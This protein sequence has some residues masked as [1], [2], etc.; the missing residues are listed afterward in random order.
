MVEPLLCGCGESYLNLGCFYDSKALGANAGAL[1]ALQKKNQSCYPAVYAH[2]RAAAA[3]EHSAREAME[4]TDAEGLYRLLRR[5][6]G[7]IAPSHS[8]RAQSREI[9]L[10]AYT[11]A[12][13][14]RY[15]V[16]CA[17][18]MALEDPCGLSAPLFARLRNHCLHAGYDCVT[19]LSPLS[20]DRLT[21]L[22]IPE[23]DTAFLADP[24]PDERCGVR[25]NLR[26][27]FRPGDHCASLLAEAKAHTEEAVR[28]LAQAK[29]AHDELEALYRPHVAFEGLD[30]LTQEYRKN[31]KAE[32]LRA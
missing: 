1:R 3:L 17:C 29:A 7:D 26:R 20:A 14:V 2:L 32:L 15:P 18:C 31:L 28:L 21:G 16:P 24:K 25:I 11:P 12:G 23:L 5:A 19:L 8:G 13:F 9:F 22:M 30:L 27:Y 6:Y 10:S 4:P